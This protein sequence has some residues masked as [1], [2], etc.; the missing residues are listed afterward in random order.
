MNMAGVKE[1]EKRLEKISMDL[2]PWE[3]MKIRDL[4]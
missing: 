4:K 1:Q 3:I 2:M